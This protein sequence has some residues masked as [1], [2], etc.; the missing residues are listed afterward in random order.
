MPECQQLAD[1]TN[2]WEQ[3]TAEL[4]PG[5]AAELG[6]S[7]VLRVGRGHAAAHTR[8]WVPGVSAWPHPWGGVQSQS[9]TAAS[10]TH[11]PVRVGAGMLGADGFG[12]WLFT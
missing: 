11:L 2:S 9:L 7:P 3:G 10:Q 6:E 8:S 12:M 1:K 5:V 4:S